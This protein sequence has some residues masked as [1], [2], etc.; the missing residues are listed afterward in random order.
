M[1]SPDGR[2]LVRR[3]R[4]RVGA[5]PRYEGE[6][7]NQ[8]GMW[9]RRYDENGTYLGQGVIKPGDITEETTAYDM[10]G[11]PVDEVVQIPHVQVKDT[12]AS[13]EFFE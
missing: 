13:Y 10:G 1:M 4:L 9:G 2:Q 3:T 5:K 6:R 8:F 12:T 11:R 7:A